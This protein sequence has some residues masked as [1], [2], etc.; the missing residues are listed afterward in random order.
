MAHD[1]ISDLKR[2]AAALEA[3]VSGERSRHAAR[4]ALHAP[5]PAR[6]P[7]RTVVAI[8]ATLLMG[9]SNVALA[10][11]A[12]P[13]VPGDAL[14]GV[15]RAYEQVAVLFGGD[16]TNAG[17]R[18][19][20][21][22]V[23]QERGKSAEALALVQETLTKLVESDDPEAAVEEFTAGLGDSDAIKAKV[24]EILDVARGVD[25]TGADVSKIAREIVDEVQLPENARG[26]P[27]GPVDPPG[28]PEDK[29]PETRPTPPVTPGQG[30]Q[31]NQG[32]KGS[33]P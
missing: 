25:T 9:V 26:N 20:E 11:V 29:G 7:R 17:E 14:Y 12:D 19:S 1:P 23:L 28:P 27:G 2:Y 32:Q 18:A 15:D 33:R 10:T 6:A 16:A 3:H 8:A 31:G 4:A 13:S 5:G 21:V 30:N 22:L 24:A